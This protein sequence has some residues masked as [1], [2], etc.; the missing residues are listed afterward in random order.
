MYVSDLKQMFDY[1]IPSAVDFTRKIHLCKII[2]EI[3]ILYCIEYIF[4]SHP[5]SHILMPHNYNKYKPLNFY[6][7]SSHL[8]TLWHY[9]RLTFYGMS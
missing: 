2:K 4:Q 8:D 3:N 6:L 7:E 9:H 5:Y 1:A